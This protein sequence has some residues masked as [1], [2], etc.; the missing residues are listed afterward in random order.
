MIC[1]ELPLQVILPRKKTHGK[2][3]IINFNNFCNWHFHARSDV[4]NKYKAEIREQL[5]GLKFYG[6]IKL[7]FVVHRP[8]KRSADRS[9]ICALHEKYFCDAMQDFR[10]IPDDNDEHIE[11]TTY[12]TGAID[13]KNPCVRVYIEEL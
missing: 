2:K 10:C 13:N 4:K 7:T 8:N 11:S 6:K 12:K 9:N 5:E 1:I 3:Y